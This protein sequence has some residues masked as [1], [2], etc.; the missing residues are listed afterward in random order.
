MKVNS[1]RNHFDTKAALRGL[2]ILAIVVIWAPCLR[3]EAADFAPRVK[4]AIQQTESELEAEKTRIQNEERARQTELSETRA[5]CKRLADELVERKISIARKQAELRRIRRRRETLW[6]ERT[7]LQEDL[8]QIALVC[9]EIE[10]E[11]A[12][13]LNV[14]PI[15]EYRPRQLEKLGDLK[16]GLSEDKAD[17][18]IESAFTVVASLLE[19]IRTTAVYSAEVVDPSGV[20]QRAQLLRIGQSMFAYH[21]PGTSHIAVAVSDPYRE[22][23][24]RW[25]E[26]LSEPM[27]QA[28]LNAINQAPNRAAVYPLPMDVTGTMTATTNLYDKTMAGRIRSGGVVMFPLAAVAVCLAVLICERLAVLLPETRHSLRFCERILDMCGKGDFEQAKELAGRTRG[29]LSRTL[30]VCLAHRNS[31][32][33][34]LDDAI[35]ETFL[36]E[37]PKLE[38]FLPSIRMLSSV[39]PI[40]G[41]LG[42][43]TGIIATFDTITVVGG[44]KPRLLAGGISEALITTATGLIIAIPG[45]LAHS[46]LSGR[47]N[48]IIA[49]T[50]R[51]AASLS[52]LIKQHQNSAGHSQDDGSQKDDAAN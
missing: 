1:N 14:I 17:V 33:A 52:N 7:R 34:V 38:R 21:L 3:A 48:G 10:R 12:E 35:Q 28:V 44:G 29:V 20:R 26:D 45:L 16:R 25:S 40:L 24:Y 31:P 39:A 5:T 43:V 27:R 30:N 18:M 19:E 11:I 23:D 13:L 8:S 50:E 46:F 6:A 36:H 51:F 9:G 49:D 22:G 4:Q 41:L 42:T 15:S 37:F 47:I 2:F 32:P